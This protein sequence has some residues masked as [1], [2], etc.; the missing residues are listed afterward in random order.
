MHCNIS[1]SHERKMAVKEAEDACNEKEKKWMTHVK[2]ASA[3]EQLH[4]SVHL[5]QNQV[6][7]LW[8]VHKKGEDGKTSKEQ[9]SYTYSH[10]KRCH[11]LGTSEK[12]KDNWSWW[13]CSLHCHSTIVLFLF[14]RCLGRLVSASNS[15][16]NGPHFL[17]LGFKTA[18]H[19][20]EDL[21]LLRSIVRVPGTVRYLV[22]Y[23]VLPVKGT[24]G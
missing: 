2:Y 4:L 23:Q 3:L 21:S 22:V 6:V 13:V 24:G 7:Q 12:S 1:L 8:K 15:K 11:Y 16:W 19:A 5:E 9:Q 17:Y 18:Y 14:F 10:W 20:R